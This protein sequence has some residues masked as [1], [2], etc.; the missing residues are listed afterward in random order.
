VAAGAVAAAVGLPFAAVP[1]AA[2][3][4]QVTFLP[5]TGLDVTPTY[6]V[7]P[8][9]CPAAA[10]NVVAVAT[11][12]GFPANGQVVVTNSMSPVSHDAPMVVH[13]Q[14]T[15]NGF[16]AVNSTK[17][18][19][20]YRV[21]VRCIDHLQQHTYATWSGT[22]TFQDGRHFTA[23]EPTQ[24][25]RDAVIA[26]EPGASPAPGGGSGPATGVSGQGSEGG[27]GPTGPGA[28]P[29][30]S[31]PSESPSADA[32]ASEP[33]DE[34]STAADAPPG[35][36]AASTSPAHTAAASAE[37]A[38]GTGWSWLLRGALLGALVCAALTV[39]LVRRERAG[40]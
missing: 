13:L 3:A 25:T 10:T 39:A 30:S 19:G 32:G 33:S 27:S 37:P 21:T 34:A 12:H 24:A 8:A 20:D 23:A 28:D 18:S 14:D 26:A 4:E 38:T 15:F 9:P 7:T 1:S 36:D 17:L 31:R 6:L 29:P 16:A 22:I 11:G 35:A 2:A 40:R 5:G